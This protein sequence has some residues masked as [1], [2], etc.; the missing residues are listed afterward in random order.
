MQ[1]YTVMHQCMQVYTS[2]YTGIHQCTP[3]YTGIH[4]Y[5]QVYPRYTPVYVHRYTQGIISVYKGTHSYTQV[6]KYAYVFQWWGSLYAEWCNVL[7][8]I[9]VNAT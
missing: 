8:T 9:I 4:H 3:V 5:T 6:C 1:V 7:M 2:I